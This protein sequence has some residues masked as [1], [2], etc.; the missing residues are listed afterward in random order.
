M[1]I[2]NTNDK[3]PND[4]RNC[5]DRFKTQYPSAIF[6]QASIRG[7][8]N[9]LAW[10]CQTLQ[11]TYS[12]M[13]VEHFQDRVE[14][15]V[16]SKL[17]RLIPVRRHKL[18]TGARAG[19]REDLKDFAKIICSDATTIIALA[20]CGH[21]CSK[22]G[23]K[24]SVGNLR[25]TF[26]KK[27][28]RSRL[29]LISIC[30]D[31]SSE[32]CMF[33][34]MVTTNGFQ[35]SLHFARPATSPGMELGLSDFKEEEIQNYFMPCALDPGDGI[36][37]KL[38]MVLKTQSMK[39]DVRL[40]GSITNGQDR[41]K[42]TKTSRRPEGEMALRR[43]N[44]IFRV[45]RLQTLHDTVNTC[46]IFSYTWKPYSHSIASTMTQRED[47]EHIKATKGTRRTMRSTLQEDKNKP[48]MKQKK[49]AKAKFTPKS[50][51]KL[52][53]VV[54]S[55]GMFGKDNVP[56]KG[57]RPGLVGVLDRMLKRREA[58]GELVVVIIDEYLTSQICH[59]C[60]GRSLKNVSTADG[61]RHH[62]LQVCKNCGILWNR[63]TNACKN[64]FHIATSIWSGNGRPG[65]F[66]RPKLQITATNAG[67]G[68]V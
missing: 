47:S 4:I 59:N 24:S 2:T 31:F 26:N 58:R 6:T 13:I 40:R 54:F 29:C 56:M 67:P 53:L 49:W 57:H 19:K 66:V 17:Q 20:V 43:S 39:F 5:W 42:G 65:P 35:L 38:H 60:Q 50:E 10:A 48:D 3:M 22:F 52:P 12:N 61:V 28:I 23:N 27:P 15:F 25:N 41:R 11:T 37:S 55:N 44:P 36:F 51:G 63:D 64:M 21:R 45:Q 16:I 1:E 46:G 18:Y 30:I 32:E 33:T 9:P 34:N 62:G 7:Y 68:W 14:K 8:A